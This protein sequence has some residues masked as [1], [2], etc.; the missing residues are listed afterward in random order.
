[1]T[2]LGRR[3]VGQAGQRPGRILVDARIFGGD[4]FI[5]I[6]A[7]PGQLARIQVAVADVRH[8]GEHLAQLLGRSV[9]FLNAVIALADAHMQIGGV[10]DRRYVCGSVPRRPHAERFA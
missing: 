5:K 7:E 1:M 6:D 2:E 8:A 9:P 4:L 3:A 10:A